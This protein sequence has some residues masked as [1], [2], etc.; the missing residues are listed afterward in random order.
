MYMKVHCLIDRM[1]FNDVFNN[2]SAIWQWSVHLSILYWSS[3]NQYSSQYSIPSHWL[4]SHI[5]IAETT[6]RGE[7][8][9]NP[10]PMTIINPRKEH[11]PN[12]WLSQRP[13][14]LKSAT[15][16]TELWVSALSHGAWHMKIQ[17]PTS[18]GFVEYCLTL[19]TLTTFV[20]ISLTI[21][22]NQFNVSV[23]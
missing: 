15:L 3:F 19:S 16:T 20:S 1:V 5:T 21:R 2:I 17:N 8:G 13:P 18:V 9:M 22:T 12:L 23:I 11:W 6:N 10:V 14:V 4:L 7:R